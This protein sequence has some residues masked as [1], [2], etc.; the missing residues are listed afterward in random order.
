MPRSPHRNDPDHSFVPLHPRYSYELVVQDCYAQDSVLVP[1][2]RFDVQSW[3]SVGDS[4][5]T[6]EIEPVLFEVR[7]P[8]AR[9]PLKQH[10]SPSSSY[11]VA[12]DLAR[13]KSIS[14]L[15]RK[16]PARQVQAG[17]DVPV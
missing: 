12:T 9:V 15:G 8:F 11:I 5:R 16:T 10:E 7:Q 4:P 14:W 17:V 6:Q 2:W 3:P 13:G 1:A